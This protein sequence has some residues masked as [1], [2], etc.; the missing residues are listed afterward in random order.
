VATSAVPRPQYAATVAGP[1]LL[2]SSILNPNL[3]AVRAGT[4]ARGLSHLLTV[5]PGEM[6]DPLGDQPGVPATYILV[7][8]AAGVLD[9]LAV[10]N[11]DKHD[12]TIGR[13]SGGVAANV[14]RLLA[15]D[16]VTVSKFAR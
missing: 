15:V 10:L 3:V 5:A 7:V 14:Y 6:G 1:L 11:P 2:P 12:Q 13:P 16:V 8:V 9:P 4:S